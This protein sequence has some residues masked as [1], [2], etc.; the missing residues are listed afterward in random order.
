MLQDEA[1]K[2]EWRVAS[3]VSVLM[4]RLAAACLDAVPS[5]M[6]S[7][8]KSALIEVCLASMFVLSSVT[9]MRVLW[10]GCGLRMLLRQPGLRPGLHPGD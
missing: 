2:A 1:V 8:K 3:C 9:V 5:N 6:S 7:R 10:R 4:E